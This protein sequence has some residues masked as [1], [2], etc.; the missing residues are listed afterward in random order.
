MA[1]DNRK[2]GEFSIQ[3]FPPAPAGVVKF[4]VT[5]EVDFNGVLNVSAVNLST[6]RSNGTT[7][8][9]NKGLLAE[10]EIRRMI[11]EAEQLKLVDNENEVR[12]RA[13]ND[14]ERFCRDLKRSLAENEVREAMQNTSA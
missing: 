12:I 4:D 2:L 14:L 7:I 11:R 6:G 13:K 8:Q 10:E 5:M 1:K 3:G 9:M